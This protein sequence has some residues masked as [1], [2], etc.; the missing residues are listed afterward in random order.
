MIDDLE[1]EKFYTVDR[2]VAVCHGRWLRQLVTPKE[3]CGDLR[4]N[5]CRHLNAGEAL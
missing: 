4:R 3:L 5:L 1:F 2:Q